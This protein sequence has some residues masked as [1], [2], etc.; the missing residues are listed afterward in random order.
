MM[1]ELLKPMTGQDTLAG[2]DEG[3]GVV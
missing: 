3:A 2:D 1:K